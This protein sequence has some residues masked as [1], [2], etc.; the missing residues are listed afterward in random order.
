MKYY[1]EM[2]E[3]TDNMSN[4]INKSVNFSQTVLLKESVLKTA[5]ECYNSFISNDTS[6]K[7]L[8]VQE[9]IVPNNGI[10]Y[11]LFITNKSIVETPPSTPNN[12][13][14]NN[15]NILFFFPAAEATSFEMHQTNRTLKH[16][17][18]EFFMEMDHVFD[19]SILFEGY[20]YNSDTF[21]ISDVL[22]VD[23][24][25][26][27]CDYS[28]RQTMIYEMLWNK[29]LSNINNHISIGIHP[30]INGN[31]PSLYT[32]FLHNFVF[33]NTICAKEVIKGHSKCT[34]TNGNSHTRL[35]GTE[36]NME[37]I[38]QKTKYADVY[39]VLNKNTK[40]TEGIL[41]IKGI[42]ESQ[43]MKSLFK[44]NTAKENLVIQCVWNETFSKWQPIL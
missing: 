16:T 33:K 14:R 13:N 4:F 25:V 19:N 41:Y 37:K 5:L 35:D 20:L 40:N 31:N 23:N 8:F 34:T 21:F 15:F 3:G 10:K 27:S 42:K 43:K 36:R 17:I 39:S 12:S 28:L 32:I 1:G 22:V 9:Y 7:S 44:D 11:Y 18:D 30:V 2:A 38:V 26:V 24:D 29:N 6:F